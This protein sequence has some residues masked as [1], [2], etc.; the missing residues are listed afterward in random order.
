M[1]LFIKAVR[2]YP[3]L[4]NTN[5][6]YYRHGDKKDIKLKK[7]VALGISGTAK[8][9][10]KKLRDNLRDS[11]KRQKCGKTGQVAPAVN[12]CKYAQIM[13]FLLPFMKN[14]KTSTFHTQ[15]TE[16]DQNST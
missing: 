8:S 12:N 2:Q 5:H 14:R 9:E 13:K 15:G 6:K 3:L 1:E 7:I 10:W 11:L 4:C 16:I